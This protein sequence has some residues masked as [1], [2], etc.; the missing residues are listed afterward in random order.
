MPRFNWVD[1]FSL[2]LFVRM[3]YMGFKLG[4][5]EELVKLTALAAG[6]MAG[7]RYGSWA[8]GWLA[9][10]SFLTEEW[11]SAVSLAVILGICYWGMRRLLS[12]AVRL[13]SVSFQEPLGC[14]G[15]L[16]AGLARAG[17]VISLVL[18]GL[19]GLPSP[20]LSAAIQ[21]RSLAG[22]SLTRVAPAVYGTLAPFFK[23]LGLVFRG[24]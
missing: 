3:G 14:W 5:G 12:L 16:V 6:L 24:G 10:K 20:Y 23:R 1:I 8:G 7:L 18:I 22:S 4:L 19:Q 9:Q 11:A 21:E 17:L 13:V 2:V 15:G